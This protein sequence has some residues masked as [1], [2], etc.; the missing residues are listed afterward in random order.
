MDI[1]GHELEAIKGMERILTANKVFLQ[2]ECFA[3]N[4]PSLDQAMA[5]LGMKRRHRIGHDHYFSNF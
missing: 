3:A 4:T 1:E 2:V 5:T